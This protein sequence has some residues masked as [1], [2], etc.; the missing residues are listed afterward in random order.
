MESK[1]IRK[2]FIVD[3]D[4]IFCR[5]MSRV[6]K[7]SSKVEEFKLFENG[8]LAFENIQNLRK[9]HYPDFI[10]LDL[11]MPFMN[12]IEFLEAVVQLEF[13]NPN[14]K[15]IISST[16]VSSNDKKKISQFDCVVDFYSKDGITGMLDNMLK[17]I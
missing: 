16:S 15:V 5:L 10:I 4:L 8:K 13:F 9:E 17:F 2:L 6:L 1:V 7:K 11:N 14:I 12:G 3:D